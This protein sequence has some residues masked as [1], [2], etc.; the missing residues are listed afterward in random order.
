MAVPRFVVL[1]VAVDLVL[2]SV[3]LAYFVLG[4]P[5]RTIAALI[6]LDGE[7]NLPTWY[8]TVQW[9]SVAMLTWVFARQHVVRA[10]VRS[11]CL[12]ALPAVFLLFSL[13]E[14]VQIHER[15]GLLSDI[16]LPNATRQGTPFFRTGLY[17]VFIGI[18]FALVFVGLIAAARPYLAQSPAGFLKL[19]SGVGLFLLA[20]GG[21]DALSNFVELG[22]FASTVQVVVEETT[23]LLAATFVLWGAYDLVAGTVPLIDAMVQPTGRDQPGDWQGGGRSGG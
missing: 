23:E 13:D 17:F 12:L 8:A 19:A 18:P 15:L 16:L 2:G 21:M 11:W 6:D 10:A 5:Y 3:Y 4:Q 9:F 14:M 7:G 1:L 22:S 20:A